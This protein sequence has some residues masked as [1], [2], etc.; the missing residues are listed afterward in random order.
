M[1]PVTF[2]TTD[3]IVRVIELLE[4]AADYCPK[5]SEGE[6]PEE[7]EREAGELLEIS[8]ILCQALKD[9]GTSYGKIRFG[10]PSREDSDLIPLDEIPF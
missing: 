5:L 2:Q 8:N 3:Q 1:I 4:E 9:S 10:G 6:D 7:K